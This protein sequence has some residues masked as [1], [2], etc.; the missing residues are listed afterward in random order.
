MAGVVLVA[1]HG[2]DRCRLSLRPLGR[3]ADEQRPRCQVPLNVAGLVSGDQG[4]EIQATHPPQALDIAGLDA[5]ARLAYF[6]R[7]R[8][9]RRGQGLRDRRSLARRAA[10]EAF[11]KIAVDPMQPPFLGEV[12]PRLGAQTCR[13]LSQPPS[14]FRPNNPLCG[15]RT[16]SI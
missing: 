13:R 3:T 1:R 10:G 2:L 16:N 7:K 15:P 4:S 6:G 14:A 12:Q 5:A 11:A 9:I 8:D